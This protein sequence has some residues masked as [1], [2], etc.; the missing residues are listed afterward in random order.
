MNWI[1]WTWL[2]GTL[3]LL[4]EGFHQAMYVAPTEATMGN[5]QR[6]FYWHFPSAMMTFLFFFVSFIASIVYLAV[7]HKHPLRALSADALALA[8]AEVGVIFCTVVLITGP[9]W[10]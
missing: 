5:I 3:A 9:L 2:A 6:I 8:S 7:R 4:G 1:R 10:A